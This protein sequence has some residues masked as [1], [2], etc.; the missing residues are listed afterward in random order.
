[1]KGRGDAALKALSR[2]RSLLEDDLGVRS[3][4]DDIVAALVEER[5]MGGSSY[6]DCFRWNRNKTGLRTLTGI[7]LQT[8]Q[9]LTGIDFISYCA[10]LVSTLPRSMLLTTTTQTASRLL[11]VQASRTRVSYPSPSTA[12]AG[13]RCS[14]GARS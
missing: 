12:S 5:E 14:S 4:R 2:L 7:A 10:L 8:W 6:A 1:M 13:A 9:Q 11:Q 3:K